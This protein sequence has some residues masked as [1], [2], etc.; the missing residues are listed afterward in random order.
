M[1][2]GEAQLK[3]P[4]VNRASLVELQK[5][6]IEAQLKLRDAE[7]EIAE[8][9]RN[10]P[11]DA[12]GKPVPFTQMPPRMTRWHATKR[13]VEAQLREPRA[14]ITAAEALRKTEAENVQ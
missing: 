7:K 5:K 13:K 10:V 11:V 8:L 3:W 12:Q 9:K 2:A 14:P 1:E 4:W 6:L